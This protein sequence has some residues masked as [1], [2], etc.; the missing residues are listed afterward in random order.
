[1]PLSY[2]LA[3]SATERALFALATSAI[4][5]VCYRLLHVLLEHLRLSKIPAVGADVGNTEKR[6]QAYLAG[7]RKLYNE[8]Y[9]KVV[10]SCDP[11]ATR[12]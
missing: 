7:A 2:A 5:F 4:A 11:E 3:N 1:M 8:G 9:K 10:R 12:S 6:R